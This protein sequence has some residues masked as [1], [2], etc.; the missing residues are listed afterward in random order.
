M[1]QKQ[2]FTDFLKHMCRDPHVLGECYQYLDHSTGYTE[3]YY[4]NG[5][6]GFQKNNILDFPVI[7]GMA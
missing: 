4:T 2:Y 6:I 1:D 5:S 7:M 3:T